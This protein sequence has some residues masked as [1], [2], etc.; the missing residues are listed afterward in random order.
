MKK[1]L[2]VSLFSLCGCL[3]A[4]IEDPVCIAD[5]LLAIFPAYR[6]NLCIADGALCVLCTPGRLETRCGERLIVHVTSLR[7]PKAV[8]TA[9]LVD[10][11]KT[12]PTLSLKH[13][14][15]IEPDGSFGVI[16]LLAEPTLIVSL[17]DEAAVRRFARSPPLSAEGFEKILKEGKC[18]GTSPDDPH[19]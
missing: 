9:P 8:C 17:R 15:Q 7:R 6:T 2:L 19:Q 10:L 18:G 16:N 14:A 5:S 13:W 11:D 12:R 1:I 4:K 3:Q